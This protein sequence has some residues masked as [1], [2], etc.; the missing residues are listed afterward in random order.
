MRTGRFLTAVGIAVA[1]VVPL[2]LTAQAGPGPKADAASED[3]GA[4]VRVEVFDEERPVGHADVP[5]RAPQALLKN[6]RA[7]TAADGDVHEIIKNGEVGDRVDIVFVGDGY[8]EAELPDFHTDVK[9]KWKDI[10]DIEPYTTHAELFNVWAVDA[11]S[12]DSGVSGDPTADVQKNTALGSHFFCNDTERLLCV[13]LPR[14]ESYAGKAPAADLVIVVSNSEKYGGAGYSGVGSPVG[15]DGVATLSSS[16]DDSGQIAIHETGH[17]LGLL[18]DEYWYDESRYEG[19]ET[20]SI[21]T[22]VYG[23]DE[24]AQRQTK[25]HRWLGEESP[26]GGTVGTYEGASYNAYGINRPTDNS[27]MRTLGREFNLPGREAMVAGFYRYATPLATDRQTE[28]A[29]KSIRDPELL[30]LVDA[31]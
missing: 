16:H 2:S 27:M 18:A 4:D 20:D 25:W 12:T 7:N 29:R 5:S 24:M 6:G 15:Y 21:N 3:R 31:K 1:A 23:A 30:K 8:T 11:V 19:D 26:D 13:D 9:E 17:S 22:S 14:V 28:A 10:T